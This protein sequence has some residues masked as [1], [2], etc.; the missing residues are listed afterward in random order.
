MKIVNGNKRYYI[1]ITILVVRLNPLR[2]NLI[3]KSQKK[4]HSPKVAPIKIVFS[5]LYQP[6]DTIIDVKQLFY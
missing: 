5:S 4:I 2:Q 1:I 3:V 6:N